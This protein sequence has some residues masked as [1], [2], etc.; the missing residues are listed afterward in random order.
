[1]PVHLDVRRRLLPGGGG[2]RGHGGEGGGPTG[3]SVA[4][5]SLAVPT[6]QAMILEEGA[7]P[8]STRHS[9]GEINSDMVLVDQSHCSLSRQRPMF[10][11]E[12]IFLSKKDNAP[13]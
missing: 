10:H 4:A 2:R 12:F 9:L 11:Q 6:R 5:G 7:D 8:Y 13:Y 1:V 3:A